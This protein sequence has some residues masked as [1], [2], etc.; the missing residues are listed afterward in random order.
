M[1]TAIRVDAYGKIPYTKIMPPAT[2][3]TRTGARREPKT[4]RI[5][6]RVAPAVKQTI[7][8]ATALSGLAVG[9]LAYAGALRVIEDHERMMLRGADRELFLRAVSKPARPMK[10]LVTALRR[11]KQLVAR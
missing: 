5:E 1:L 11:H 4:E 6:V 9:D 10:R 7:R 3:T 8:R 2:Q